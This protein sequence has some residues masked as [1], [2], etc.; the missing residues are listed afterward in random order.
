MGELWVLLNFLLPA[1]FA[2]AESFASWFNAPFAV[3]TLA[4]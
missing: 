3:S 4:M 2:S 1:I